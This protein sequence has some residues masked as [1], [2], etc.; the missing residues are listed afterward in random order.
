MHLLVRVPS[1]S[2]T[3]APRRAFRTHLWRARL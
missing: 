3:R 2:P 1:T